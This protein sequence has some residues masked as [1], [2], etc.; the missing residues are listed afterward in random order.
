MLRC[1]PI[2]SPVSPRASARRPDHSSVTSTC[3]TLRD[4]RAVSSSTDA[5]RSRSRL[6]GGGRARRALRE[7]RRRHQHPSAHSRQH[8][9][10]IARHESTF[11]N[12]A[13][14]RTTSPFRPRRPDCDPWPSLDRAR[15]RLRGITTH[16]P[17]RLDAAQ[18]GDAADRIE[19]RAATPTL[20]DRVPAANGRPDEHR[21]AARGPRGARSSATRWTWDDG[22]PRDRHHEL[23]A[24]VATGDRL[25]RK[26]LGR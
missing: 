24:A 8:A 6:G 17:R 16:P 5:L 13:A 22:A 1:R 7:R 20:I 26:P 23:V 19:R 9:R 11:R 15:R 10:T 12:E 3:T 25:G 14:N 4:T 2:T 21:G 18:T